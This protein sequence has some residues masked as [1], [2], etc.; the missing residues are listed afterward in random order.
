MHIIH[1]AHTHRD[2]HVHHTHK[3]TD[4]H[5]CI[6]RQLRS[7]AS[8]PCPFFTLTRLS[9]RNPLHTPPSPP[10]PLP[11]TP[12]LPHLSR[13]K[14]RSTWTAQGH[15]IIKRASIRILWKG[16][17]T[18]TFF[19]LK[20]LCI[21]LFATGALHDGPYSHSV[22]RGYLAKTFRVYGLDYVL[23]HKP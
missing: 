4:V 8:P 23:N 20:D 5:A 11:P 10:T 13:R 17:C 12:S 3:Y 9:S 7:Q 22:K 16:A 1:H 18:S 19:F 14:K 15:R 6:Y 21:F 2:I